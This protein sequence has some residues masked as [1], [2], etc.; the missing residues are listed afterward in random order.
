MRVCV[1]VRG[2]LR[3]YTYIVYWGND[4]WEILAVSLCR[5][6]LPVAGGPHISMYVYNLSMYVYNLRYEA[7]QL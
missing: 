5:A 7:H 2:C 6:A 1:H 4:F 3:L